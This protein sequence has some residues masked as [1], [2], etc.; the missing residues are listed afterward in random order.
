MKVKRIFAQDIRSGMLKMKRTLGDDA[1]ILANRQT[2]DGV[3]LIVG[4]EYDPDVIA[5]LTAGD[6]GP[7]YNSSTTGLPGQ[8]PELVGE[9]PNASFAKTMASL[10]ANPPAA[11]AAQKPT[12]QPIS[13][14]EVVELQE[15]L[16]ADVRRELHMLG[17]QMQNQLNYLGWG[18]CV[19]EAPNRANILRQLTALGL[20]TEFSKDIARHISSDM[21]PERAWRRALGLWASRLEVKAEAIMKR[22]GIVA[23]MGP[24][25][26]GKTTTA[27]KLAARFAARHGK[28]SV[29]L[30][31]N[32]NQRIGAQEQLLGL[33]R[34]L[35][36]SVVSAEDDREL[37]DILTG[38]RKKKLILIDTAGWHPNH[39]FSGPK[40]TLLFNKRI[41]I[42]RY[43]VL[44]CNSQLA[45]LDHIV[46]TYKHLHFNGCILTK[47]DEAA[48][49]GGILTVVASYKLPLAYVTHGHRVPEDIQ[50]AKVSLLL[51]KAVALSKATQCKPD[52]DIMAM[53]YGGSMARIAV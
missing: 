44:S 20:G 48:S 50:S 35:G 39:S 17:S 4:T 40:R 28:H 27:A 30:V 25:G 46:R 42:Q 51:S 34:M 10:P 49:L 5:A 19:N 7:K 29:L 32:D 21:E 47:L 26:V 24:T 15:P 14:A 36:I 38:T 1:V 9:L 41:A 53:R 18:K 37:R 31:A 33:G 6:D 13:K 23:L 43:M 11:P 2:A 3:E 12:A 52:E 45:S 22:G 8:P 16:I